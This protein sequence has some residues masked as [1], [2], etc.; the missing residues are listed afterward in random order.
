LHFEFLGRLAS[1]VSKRFP[2]HWYPGNPGFWLVLPDYY[3]VILSEQDMFVRFELND[4]LSISAWLG[5]VAYVH[6]RVTRPYGPPLSTCTVDIVLYCL[7]HWLTKF[8]RTQDL[9]KIVTCFKKLLSERRSFLPDDLWTRLLICC[10]SISRHTELFWSRTIGQILALFLQNDKTL[11]WGGTQLAMWWKDLAKIHIC[12]GGSST[13]DIYSRSISDLSPTFYMLLERP[14]Y[15]S[16]AELVEFWNLEN[17]IEVHELIRRSCV[18]NRI[19]LRTSPVRQ[20]TKCEE[21]REM[22]WAMRKTRGLLFESRHSPGSYTSGAGAT[23]DQLQ[24]VNRSTKL[25]EALSNVLSRK[26]EDIRSHLGQVIG[27]STILVLAGEKA[28]ISRSTDHC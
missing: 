6:W 23:T 18:K 13:V 7:S 11:G 9:E 20:R 21:F 22:S 25:I 27:I 4:P 5:N 28:L 16:L 8:E 26:L 3:P 24:D 1:V 10:A 2:G 14:N 15:V 12:M 17:R 19:K